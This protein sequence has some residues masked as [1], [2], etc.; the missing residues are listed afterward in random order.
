MALGVGTDAG[1][2]PEFRG[3]GY[4]FVEMDRETEIGDR[5]YTDAHVLKGRLETMKIDVITISM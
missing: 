2:W 1:N 3:T 4:A 5:S